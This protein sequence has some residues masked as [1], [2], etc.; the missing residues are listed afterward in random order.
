[1]ILIDELVAYVRQF[2]E[3]K[4]LTGGTFDSN[5]SFIQALTEA[6]KAV[7]MRSCWPRCPNRTRKPA[8][9]AASRRWPAL[10]HYFGR[11]Q[12]LWKPVA[13]K[14]RSRSCAAACLASINDKLAA[15]SVCRAFADFY[16]A[17][18][19]RLSA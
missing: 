13:P 15:E 11:I 2:E 1:V 9:S 12:A 5:L 19:H 16:T 18:A 4:A 17:N 14:R 10:A 7:P 8:A 6:L 3:G